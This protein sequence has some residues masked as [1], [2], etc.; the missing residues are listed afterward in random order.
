MDKFKIINWDYIQ[1]NL[2]SILY[3]V[4]FFLV[5]EI[6]LVAFFGLMVWWGVQDVLKVSGV[7]LGV[8]IV[9]L[10]YFDMLF[11]FICIVVNNFNNL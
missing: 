11:C 9:F 1:V 4:V 2:D 3:Y 10:V 6:I 5:V 7:I 8:L